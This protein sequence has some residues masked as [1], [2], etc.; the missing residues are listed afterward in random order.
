MGG[1]D[2]LDQLISL[3]RIYIRSRKWTLRLIF[4]AVDFAIVNSWLEYRRD[5]NKLCIPKK[6]VL[7]LMQFRM[8]VAE[9][10]IKVGKVVSRKRGRPSSDSSSPRDEKSPRNEKSRHECKPTREVRMDATDH[11]PHLD[12]NKEGKRCKY[13]KCNRK[14]HFYCDKCGVHLCIT[15]DRNCFVDFHRA[16]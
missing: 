7:D 10:L 3:Y 15:K 8:R 12:G 16:K 1:V 9:G 6:N 2:L 13:A 4:H 11:M 14:T 5:C